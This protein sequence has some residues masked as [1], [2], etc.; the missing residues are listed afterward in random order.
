MVRATSRADERQQIRTARTAKDAG[1]TAG[2]RWMAG[3]PSTAPA[4]TA[5]VLYLRGFAIAF[6]CGTW[7]AFRAHHVQSLEPPHGVGSGVDRV[8][9]AV[10]VDGHLLH[11][12]HRP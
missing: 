8:G 2:A 6:W 7:H 1:C 3:L 4:A 10:P 11:S 5:V 12:R 9:C